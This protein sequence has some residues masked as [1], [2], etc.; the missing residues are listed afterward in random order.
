MY[1]SL[2]TWFFSYL[3][4]EEDPGQ[5]F[6]LDHRKAMP[7]HLYGNSPKKEEA[8]NGYDEDED[9]NEIDDYYYNDNDPP[10][11]AGETE[12]P[13]VLQEELLPEK[14]QNWEK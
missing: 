6:S 3:E 7:I 1:F 11:G 10:G 4:I 12:N 14:P 8:Y 5:G 2:E 13:S 9:H